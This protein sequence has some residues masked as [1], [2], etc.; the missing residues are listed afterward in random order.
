[1]FMAPE[2]IAKRAFDPF[3]AD[4][5]SLGVTFYWMAMGESPWGAEVDTMQAIL[6]GIPVL[7]SNIADPEF[8]HIMRLMGDVDPSKRISAHSLAT[9]PLFQPPVSRSSNTDGKS[10][11]MASLR[12][13]RC[14]RQ[15]ERGLAAKATSSPL[16]ATS[17]ATVVSVKAPMPKVALKHMSGID[18]QRTWDRLD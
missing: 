9:H 2:I 17:S 15:V 6:C 14:I 18:S 7:P 4:V 5:W 11:S 16:R 3:M 10:Q 13:L 8:R 12:S 1:M